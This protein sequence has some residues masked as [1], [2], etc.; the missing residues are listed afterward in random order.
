MAKELND[1][2]KR[3]CG[4]CPYRKDV[5]S[6][7]WAANE[8]EKLPAYDAEMAFQPIA[9][10]DCHQRDGKLCA[11]WLACHGPHALLAIRWGLIAGKID[12]EVLDYSTDVPL[13]KSG[14]EACDHG[15]RDIAN[16]GEAA[17]RKIMGLLKVIPNPEG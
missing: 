15:K 12:P 5:P 3:P 13:F 4:T 10:F 2:A 16:P 6:G 8:Y 17:G 14:Q 9:R 11:G 7:V 1:V